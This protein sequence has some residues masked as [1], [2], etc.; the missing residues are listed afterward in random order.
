MVDSI[1]NE[2]L[3]AENIIENGFSGKN[4]TKRE[5]IL[6]AKYY[7]WV[8]G[9]GS[10]KTKTELIRFCNENSDNFNVI[11]NSNLV[12]D[13]IRIAKKDRF[14]KV[15]S[16]QITFNEIG[17]IKSVKNFEYQKILFVFLVFAK[18]LKFIFT[19]TNKKAS[20]R[21]QI[22][23]YVSNSFI[24]KIKKISGIRI[25]KKKFLYI[26]NYF[27]NEN[28]IEPTYFDSNR[29]LFVEEK[30]KPAIVVDN[31]NNI[32]EFYIKYCGGELY[33]CSNCGS[34]GKKIGNKKDLCY[35]CMV[36]KRR[37]DVR[38]NVAKHREKT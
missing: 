29:I 33:Y 27:F 15:N 24:P 7:M 9:H 23:Y 30:G 5:M 25:S 28:L 20:N 21:L 14:K 32:V 22:G 36:E 37:E 26:L 13:V 4:I 8:L 35:D 34:E 3:I 2:A 11:T 6:I 10:A 18:A 19:K 12:N 17:K 31:F 16:V 1:F 38:E